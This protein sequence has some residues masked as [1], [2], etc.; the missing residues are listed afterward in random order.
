MVTFKKAEVAK[1]TATGSN[2]NTDGLKGNSLFQKKFASKFLESD[3]AL[4]L[5]FKKMQT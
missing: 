4:G 3:D 1:K 5:K 2:I